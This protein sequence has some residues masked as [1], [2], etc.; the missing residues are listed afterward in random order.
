[1]KLDVIFIREVGI[2]NIYNRNVDKD[3]GILFIVDGRVK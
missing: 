3:V 2:I 1:M